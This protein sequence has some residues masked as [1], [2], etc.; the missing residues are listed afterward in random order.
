MQYV[1]GNITTSIVFSLCFKK[2]SFRSFS[3]N[4]KQ[5]ETAGLKIHHLERM[6]DWKPN[7]N[8]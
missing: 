3:M 4:S 2:K 1:R 6:V 8:H 7:L 5:K